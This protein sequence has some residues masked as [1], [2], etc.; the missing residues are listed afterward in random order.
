[1]WMSN[2]N[3]PT[4]DSIYAMILISEAAFEWCQTLNFELLRNSLSKYENLNNIGEI[5]NSYERK[6]E[7]PLYIG[8]AVMYTFGV[9]I[10]SM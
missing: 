8:I 10:I 2:V 4:Y 5:N 6:L 7:Y 1:M 9:I 3:D